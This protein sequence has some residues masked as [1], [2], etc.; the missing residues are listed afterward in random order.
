VFVSVRVALVCVYSRFRLRGEHD[1]NGTRITHFQSQITS[2]HL[3]FFGLPLFTMEQWWPD[4]ARGQKL[5]T[6]NNC[7]I[8]APHFLSWHF[9]FLLPFFSGNNTET[10]KPTTTTTAN[11][12]DDGDNQK[13]STAT[14]R[15]LNSSA[16]GLPAT[17][18]AAAELRAH[19]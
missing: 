18:N 6:L 1:D 7:H 13:R 2:T 8:H 3:L 16:K 14:T 9:R 5:L 15:R 19:V 12:N 4:C 17:G 10:D 11:D